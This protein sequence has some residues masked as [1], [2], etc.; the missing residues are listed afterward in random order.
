MKKINKFSDNCDKLQFGDYILF[1]EYRSKTVDGKYEFDVSK[2]IFAIYLGFFIADMAMSFNYVKWINEKQYDVTT[3]ESGKSYSNI[4]EVSGIDSHFEWS[5]Y[6]DILGIWKVRP[7][8][9]EII[10][11][12]RNQETNGSVKEFDIDWVNE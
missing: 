7:T 2:P 5:D 1:Q 3:N 8:W 12:Y 9:K 6:I 10:S 4:R 11:K